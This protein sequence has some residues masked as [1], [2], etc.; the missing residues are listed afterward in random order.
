MNNTPS[1][2]PSNGTT[3]LV[4]P[5]TMWKQTA[6]PLYQRLHSS[7]FHKAGT[8]DWLSKRRT[9]KTD[10][11]SAQYGAIYSPFVRLLS[12]RCAMGTICRWRL[13]AVISPPFLHVE[14]VCI[15]FTNYDG[16]LFRD[17]K[18]SRAGRRLTI[19]PFCPCLNLSVYVSIKRGE[20]E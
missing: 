19:L 7:L 14:S 20:R 1:P 2:V 8:T 3:P 12:A 4:N 18:C 16:T 17:A 11:R 9:Y 10:C 6:N 13:T 15:W 5:E